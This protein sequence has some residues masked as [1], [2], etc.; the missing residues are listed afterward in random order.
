MWTE[1]PL[2][3][4]VHMVLCFSQHLLQRSARI[5]PV[6]RYLK[7]HSESNLDE[8]L[9]F[10]QNLT[11]GCKFLS[12]SRETKLS[13]SN[14][15]SSFCSDPPQWSTFSLGTL[16]SA[17]LGRAKLTAKDRGLEGALSKLAAKLTGTVIVAKAFLYSLLFITCNNKSDLLA[18]KFYYIYVVTEFKLRER[19]NVAKVV[20]KFKYSWE[21]I[22]YIYLV[23]SN[24][25][26][27]FLTSRLFP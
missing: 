2:P 16:L 6:S 12:F 8:T 26:Q 10:F 4:Q 7:T 23:V 22:I 20:W 9:V 17:S 5:K 15:W 18:V 21:F 14:C 11:P 19:T 1:S 27:G 13:L 24:A 25:L 3:S